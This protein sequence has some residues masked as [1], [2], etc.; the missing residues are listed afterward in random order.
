MK[1]SLSPLPR[2]LG[3]AAGRNGEQVERPDDASQ[4][5]LTVWARVVGRQCYRRTWFITF[6]VE[7]G[8]H[9]MLPYYAQPLPEICEEGTLTLQNGQ[10]VSFERG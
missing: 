1:Y 9:I 7:N 4:A 2:H 10:C 6:E 3:K 5:R 8:E